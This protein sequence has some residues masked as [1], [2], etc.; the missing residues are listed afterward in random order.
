MKPYA[1]LG[2]LAFAVAPA[3]ALADV[4]FADVSAHSAA[5]GVAS[6]SAKVTGTGEVFAEYA[7]GRKPQTARSVKSRYAQDGLIAMW[8]GEDNMGTGAHDP[9]ATTWRDLVGTHP[10]M[11]FTARPTVGVNYYEL[12][13]GGCGTPAGDIGGSLNDG[14]TTVEVVCTVNKVVHDATL[15]ACVDGTNTTTGAAGNRMAWVRHQVSG[16]T[17]AII[18]GL[19]Y[20]GTQ[21]YGVSP[22]LD[23][24]TGA[25]RHYA[26]MFNHPDVPGG[27]V[28]TTN[29][30]YAAQAPG[31]TTKGTTAKTWFSLGQRVCAAGTSAAISDIRIHCVRVYNRTLTNAERLAN[32]A[33]DRE[34]FESADVI[35][36]DN[37]G[38][39]VVTTTRLGTVGEPITAKGLYAQDGLIAMWDGEDNQGTG[40]H[41]AGA[42]TWADLTGRHAAMQFDTAPTVG[43]NHYD[44]SKGGGCVKSCVDIAQAIQ[45]KNATIEIVCDV[46]SL[47]ESGTLVS[48]VDGAAADGGAGNRLVWI[49]NGKLASNHEGVIGTIDYLTD[50]STFPYPAYD[51]VVN[52]IRSYSLM[53]DSARCSVYRDGASTAGTTKTIGNSGAVTLGNADTACFSIGQRYSQTGKS[54]TI[55]DMKVYCVRVYDRQLTAE[56]IAANH[57]I[58]VKRF[59]GAES[60]LPIGCPLVTGADGST[61]VAKDGVATFRLPGLRPDVTR[62][63]VRLASG[64]DAAA[65]SISVPFYSASEAAASAWFVSV[66]S[67]FNSLSRSVDQPNAAY[68]DLGFAG[69]NRVPVVEA[70]FQM[71]AKS[72]GRYAFGTWSEKTSTGT[73]AGILDSAHFRLRTGAV[74]VLVEATAAELTAP[75]ELLLNAPAGTWLDGNLVSEELSGAPDADTTLN[76]LLFAR[77]HQATIDGGKT[78][79]TQKDW[80]QARIWNFKL[81]AD[82]QPVRDLV[83]ANGPDGRAG[84]FDRVSLTHLPNAGTLLLAHGAEKPGISLVN[85]I[86]EMGKLRL[87]LT[88]AGTEETEVYV[89]YGDSHGNAAPADWEHFEKLPVG[90]GAGETSL[91]LTLAANVTA[92]TYVRLF[93]PADG[94]SDTA[95]IPETRVR[96]GLAIIVK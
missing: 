84:F 78:Y 11:T 67:R 27:V 58:D 31:Q 69:D 85:P 37:P 74:G 43:E 8:D 73:T 13:K 35:N 59:Y 68:V 65:K 87:T 45:A 90:F 64:A 96:K 36:L 15:F 75:H 38:R 30:V 33:A 76:Y 71:L 18:G 61:S 4:S 50:G 49:M 86:I 80:S 17:A 25:V 12:T 6:V 10:D 40:A 93:T 22:L 91:D 55:S 62:Y 39:A 60:E 52:R 3:A 46:R 79:F 29:G 7:H 16:Q 48:L 57:A 81:S 95:F 1:V 2:V 89:A 83:P 77:N 88:R 82:G 24:T 26:F 70:K 9:H 63:T 5:P 44:V 21:Y 54:G 34:R 94:W 51:T 92:S 56:E 19:E 72:D 23:T 66:D 14:E 32:L 20:K 47:V 28:I 42:T 53:F 41:V